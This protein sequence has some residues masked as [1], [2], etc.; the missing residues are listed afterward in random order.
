MALNYVHDYTI[1]GRLVL[2]DCLIEDG[3]VAVKDG[4]IVYS[5]AAAG[6]P[7]V[8]EVINADGIIAPGFVDIHCHSGGEFTGHENPAYVA[9]HHLS[10][11]TTSMLL[12][13][14]RDLG[15]ENMVR[16]INN[17]KELMVPGSNLL[18]VHLEG[19]YLNPDYGSR[20]G[21]ETPVDEEKYKEFAASGIIRQWTYAPEVEGTEEFVKYVVSQGIV[22]SIGHSCA[23]VEQVKKAEEYGARIVTHLFDATGASIS[24]TRYGGTIEVTFDF[25]A[26]LCDNLMYE[27]ILDRDGVHVRHD[28]AKL[29]LKLVGTDRVIGITDSSTGFIDDK[30]CN[31]ENGELVGSKMTMDCAA[32]NWLSL[33]LSIPEVF[34]ITAENPA[35]ALN[36]SDVVGSL[37][38][39]RRGDCVVVDDA[40]NVKE[41]YKSDI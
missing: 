35:R 15:H 40:L 25:A 11:G 3:A 32:R 30:D 31:F 6:A 37:R 23:S 14:Y 22:P 12:T 2:G 38:V 7:V 28:M 1:Y 13:F 39:G 41:I 21:F 26:L 16:Y 10:H 4:I 19:P 8:G 17:V 20:A 36:M 18:G 9:N 24:P 33:G 5:G 34:K 29:V 27:I